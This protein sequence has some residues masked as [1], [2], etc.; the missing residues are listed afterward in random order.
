MLAWAIPFHPKLL[1]L[2]SNALV[3]AFEI[4][5]PVLARDCWW[6]TKP[7]AIYTTGFRKQCLPHTAEELKSIHWR[8]RSICTLLQQANIR[9]SVIRNLFCNCFTSEPGCGRPP[10]RKQHIFCAYQLPCRKQA[11]DSLA[12]LAASEFRI[13]GELLPDDCWRM[14]T[15]AYLQNIPDG[16]K[17]ELMCGNHESRYLLS[18][19]LLHAKTDMTG[20][21]V[22]RAT[23]SL[24][25]IGNFRK[26]IDQ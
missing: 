2:S 19:L 1:P 18:K 7:A 23:T 24:S 6:R 4:L 14:R 11:L 8:M 9:T 12:I 3:K 21:N 26:A 17:T 25:S 15:S 5:K 10:D 22:C 16:A 20:R 13:S